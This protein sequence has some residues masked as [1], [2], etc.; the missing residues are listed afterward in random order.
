MSFN[1]HL[2]DFL[3]G[4]VGVGV[5]V[6]IVVLTPDEESPSDRTS[7]ITWDFLADSGVGF[8]AS[9]VRAGVV[10]A[11]VVLAGVDFVAGVVRA[12]VVFFVIIV[13]VSDPESSAR[14]TPKDLE[15]SA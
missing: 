8:V 4:V 12:G 5:V 2:I 6:V 7:A 9:V 10:R 1:V 14:A 3:F 11:G 13:V 15:I